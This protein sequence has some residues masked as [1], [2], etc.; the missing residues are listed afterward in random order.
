MEVLECITTR[1]CIRK[2]QKKEIQWDL[3][4]NVLEA[5]RF[6]P[7]AGNLQNWKFVVILD[8]DKRNAIAEA[9]VKQFWMAEA[10][11]H[12]IIIGEP[13]KAKRH[14]GDRG[15]RLYTV[16]GCA[17]AMENMML[18]AHNLGLGSCWVGAFDEDKIRSIIGA[19][20]EARPQAI[21]TVGYAAE[22]PE[23]PTRYPL[24]PM[25]YFNKWRGRIRNVPAY[26]MYYSPGIKR[27]VLKGKKIAEETG[28]KAAVKAGEIAQKIKKKLAERKKKKTAELNNVK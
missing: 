10:P 27:R 9:C 3:V 5:G 21:V 28:K 22:E 8:E 26:F 13:E 24:E 14:Y 17:A 1:R 12:I 4:S 19:P 20:K 11:L 25:T 23:I 15:E 16:Q 18:E 7:S 2:Y 6:A